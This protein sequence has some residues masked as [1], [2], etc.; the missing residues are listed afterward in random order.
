MDKNLL[1][2]K[3]ID[4]RERMVIELKLED[5]ESENGLTEEWME[6]ERLCWWLIRSGWNP[7]RPRHGPE[8]S[9]VGD[10]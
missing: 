3:S 7:R 4:R 1:F 10:M 6:V 2:V 5:D 9:K 8:W